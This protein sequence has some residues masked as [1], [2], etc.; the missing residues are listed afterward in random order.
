MV[1]IGKE[2][3]SYKFKE[4]YAENGLKFKGYIDKEMEEFKNFFPT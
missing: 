1:C 2:G 4:G 3:S